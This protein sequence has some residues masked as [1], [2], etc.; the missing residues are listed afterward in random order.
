MV[1]AKILKTEKKIYNYFYLEQVWKELESEQG[2]YDFVTRYLSE[3]AGSFWNSAFND[4]SPKNYAGG[5]GLYFAIDPHISKSYGNTFIQLT[6]PPGTRFINV[7]NPIPV[8][9]ETMAAL[10]ADGV[11]TASQIAELFPKQAG[12]YRDTLRAMVQP[13][14]AD[15]RRLVQS[16]FTTNNIQFVEYNFNSSLSTFCVKHS[17]S[18]F[19]FVGKSDPQNEKIGIVEPAL[20]HSGVMSTE[21]TIPGLSAEESE[22][23]NVVIKFRD[24]LDFL[25]KIN[26]KG[27]SYVKQYIL[28]Q[29]TP[30]E[31]AAVKDAAYS[32]E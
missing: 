20:F 3:R 22:R 32:C 30:T 11:I 15:F 29:Y 14:F 27:R 12:F 4:A 18:A 26:S 5:A 6:M 2:R 31:Y 28:Q 17:Y 10:V 19:V 25:P 13:Q 21:L 9:K 8:K 7:V 24:I 16:I 23:F 1:S